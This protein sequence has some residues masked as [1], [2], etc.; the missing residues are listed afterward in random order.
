[1]QAGSA[2]IREAKAHLSRLIREVRRGREWVI[3]ERGRP[4]ARLIPVRAA[5][6]PLEERIRRLEEA[7]VLEPAPPGSSRPL[8]PPL[9]LPDGLAQRWLREDREA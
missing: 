9:P 7:G 6:L 5:D 1:M 2:G 8:P 3:T 4:V